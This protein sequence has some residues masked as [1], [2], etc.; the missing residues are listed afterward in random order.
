MPTTGS[1]PWPPP[2]SRAPSASLSPPM[3]GL[4]LRLARPGR[5]MPENDAAA[6]HATVVAIPV[7][8]AMAACWMQVAVKRPCAHVWE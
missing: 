4:R 3:L 8:T 1:S 2:D 7:D 5:L 6:R